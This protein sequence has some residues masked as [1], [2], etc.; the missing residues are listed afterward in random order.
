GAVGEWA[1]QDRAVQDFLDLNA[2]RGPKAQGFIQKWLLLLPMPLPAGEKSGEQ[3]L[4]RQQLPGEAQLRPRPGERGQVAGQELHWQKHQSPQAVLD[5]NAALGREQQWSVA[6]AVCYL[7]SDRPRDGLW[8]QVISDDQSK[9]YLNSQ[10][11]YECR[12]V[13]ELDFLDTA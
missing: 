11:V 12:Q 7:E 2:F 6:Y 13:R 4:D 10:Q 5:F 3:G 1:H 9:V 8:L